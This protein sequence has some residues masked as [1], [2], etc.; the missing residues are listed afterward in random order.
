MT[1]NVIGQRMN[2]LVITHGCWLVAIMVRRRRAVIARIWPK[3]CLFLSIF[4]IY[5]YLL[6][7]GIPPALCI[8]ESCN[9]YHNIQLLKHSD[10]ETLL[11]VVN[12]TSVDCIAHMEMN[13]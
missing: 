3:Y 2:F 9:T 6:C 5:Q 8:G 12:F 10:G 7:V 4:M 13:I 1:V 11:S